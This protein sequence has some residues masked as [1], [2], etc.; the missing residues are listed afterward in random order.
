M[1][2]E[3]RTYYITYNNSQRQVFPRNADNVKVVSEPEK[4]QYFH[5]KKLSGK[6]QFVDNNELG[7]SDFS[8]FKNIELSV[9]N[10]NEIKFEVRRKCGSA[11]IT[12]FKGYFTTS[13]GAFDF[14]RCVFEI[15]PRT[16]DEYRCLL[17][18]WDK[19][20]N[21]LDITDTE[22][23]TAYIPLG[24]TNFEYMIQRGTSNSNLSPALT[25]PTASWKLLQQGIDYD[26]NGNYFKIYYR[27]VATTSCVGGVPQPPSGTGWLL[28]TDDC[29]GTNTA[30]YVRQPLANY[31]IPNPAVQSGICISGT[32]YAPPP[33]QRKTLTLGSPVGGIINSYNT[34]TG[35]PV[36]SSVWT[37]SYKVDAPIS[38]TFQWQITG[39]AAYYITGLSGDT[40]DLVSFSFTSPPPFFY[41]HLY[42]LC[43][44]TNVNGDEIHHQFDVDVYNYGVNNVFTHTAK[45][46]GSTNICTSETDIVFSVPEQYRIGTPT[47]SVPSELAI[48]SGQGTWEITCHAT[49]SEVVNAIV[50]IQIAISGIFASFHGASKTISVSKHPLT[51]NIQGYEQFLQTDTIAKYKVSPRNGSTYNWEVDGGTIDSGNGTNEIQVTWGSVAGD[52]EVRVKETMTCGCSWLKIIDCATGNDT[53]YYWCPPTEG[54]PIT[55]GR[56]RYLNDAIEYLLSQLP[57]DYDDEF[58]SDFFEHN[59]VGDAPDYSAG[60]N[61][62]SLVV[63]KL[64]KVTIYQK[65]D[66]K[67]YNSSNAATVG[68]ITLK[69]MLEILRDVFKVYWEIIPNGS[70]GYKLRLE[71]YKFFRLRQGFDTTVA[72]YSKQ[73]KSTNKYEHLN[74]TL[75]KYERFAWMEAQNEDFVGTEIYYDSLCVN[76]DSDNNASET[77]VSDVT[78]DLLEII[79][80]PDDISD[81]GWVLLANEDDGSGGLQVINE[82]GLLSGVI[83]PNGHLSWANLHYSYHRFERQLNSGN[84]NNATTEFFL[85]KPNIKQTT[86]E[87]E[88]C[89]DDSLDLNKGVI[90]QLG[91]KYLGGI[92]GFIATAEFPLTKDTVK[93]TLLYSYYAS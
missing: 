67:L 86:F 5:R 55:I 28:L 16:D 87:I 45:I 11:Y 41:G 31:P 78:T 15:L 20:I 4:D 46:E 21:L 40:T 53:P 70:G 82:A 56:G 24:T 12:V 68:E 50:G 23:T 49:G 22:D 72:R 35:L 85:P 76:Q 14:D 2:N 51:D 83:M 57:C 63:N 74:D 89:C 17:E 58:C 60:Y 38:S 47:W 36:L 91:Y 92:D 65:S 66:V 81:D 44:E 37:V 77:N 79:T 90:T 26:P 9:N 62:V 10:C 34:I 25:T 71:H 64:D 61:Y 7:I 48:D 52:F 30:T 80:S 73:M 27:E 1:A 33:V 3:Q 8:F 43:I 39:T 88:L 6:F 69:R 59:P 29:S 42:L 84:M 93:L 13:M 19:K 54:T 18:H 32:A 75:M